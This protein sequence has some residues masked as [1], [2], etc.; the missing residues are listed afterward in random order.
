MAATPVQHVTD[1]PDLSPHHETELA[2][3]EDWKRGAPTDKSENAQESDS[4]LEPLLAPEAVQHA[5]SSCT[6]QP[7]ALSETASSSVYALHLEAAAAHTPANFALP[8]VEAVL[9]QAVEADTA[10]DSNQLAAETPSN[11]AQYDDRP[12]SSISK[13]SSN[14]FAAP[15]VHLQSAEETPEEGAPTPAAAAAHMAP[16]AAATDLAVTCEAA[17][18]KAAL[19]VACE[20]P[21]GNPSDPSPST[22]Q[23][24]SATDISAR[25]GVLAGSELLQEET[26]LASSDAPGSS[27]AVNTA[28]AVA[29]QRYSSDEADQVLAQK[30][31]QTDAAPGL[32]PLSTGEDPEFSRRAVPDLLDVTEPS[33]VPAALS[34]SE[35]MAAEST[36]NPSQ[37]T[38]ALYQL[39]SLPLETPS[40]LPSQLSSS[41]TGAPLDRSVS[42][43][44]LI[45]DVESESLGTPVKP[46]RRSLLSRLRPGK[47]AKRGS[48]LGRTASDPT[49]L[50][51]QS[52]AELEKTKS[53]TKR[54]SLMGL[55]HR[56][57]SGS[58]SAAVV[59]AAVVA[60][61]SG[62][63][64]ATAA[65]ASI[66]LVG[67][68]ASAVEREQSGFEL[69]AVPDARPLLES[70]ISSGSSP[71]LDQG[72]QL[73]S[74][75]ASP[76]GR[77]GT[78]P[79]QGTAVQPDLTLGRAVSDSSLLL[80]LPSGMHSI[81]TTPRR[82]SLLGRMSRGR[83]SN[84][85]V[86]EPVT[87]P[88]PGQLEAAQ[89]MPL[90]E[91][92]LAEQ[93]FDEVPFAEQPF[94]EQPFVEQPL[95]EQPSD[96]QP[97][98]EQAFPEQPF[99]EQH[100]AEQPPAAEQP[101][102][103][104]FSPGVAQNGQQL[105]EEESD[106]SKQSL[107]AVS[108]DPQPAEGRQHILGALKGDDSD[109]GVT[110]RAVPSGVKGIAGEPRE[111]ELSAAHGPVKQPLE[112]QQPE[113]HSSFAPAERQDTGSESASS[114]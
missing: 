11:A 92:P 72:L 45:S 41:Q 20:L 47:G 82:K 31:L 67:S 87:G 104:A 86:P 98:A 68:M 81:P 23:V 10:A 1:L 55:L 66:D 111:P 108:L 33:Q 3:Q 107:D 91:V 5:V 102:A 76:R 12:H 93:P 8:A 95:A 53:P 57:S 43:S 77:G 85:I 49:L 19:T 70:I 101:S 99:A 94:A 74:A 38:Q 105:C 96:E 50:T 90:Q 103:M 46:K 26:P 52:S 100:L 25:D 60:S 35:A 73:Q 9:A 4:P 51:R 71:A 22:A 88:M 79:S 97:S 36:A 16:A 106:H 63:A 114:P 61:S 62:P 13:Q 29:L 65:G 84:S 58:A 6:E 109:A 17:R 83:R 24:S 42:E 48:D 40:Q 75:L 110:L 18:V 44:S 32:L 27:A 56:G 54:M 64:P 89:G 28:E 7:E 78:A 21:A 112:P 30:M 15:A 39:W 113:G 37:P 14:A 80:R 2:H 59:K 69:Q 34:D